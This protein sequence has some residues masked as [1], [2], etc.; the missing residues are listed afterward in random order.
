MVKG[1]RVI[2]RLASK[3]NK[4]VTRE[5]SLHLPVI[6]GLALSLLQGARRRLG[7]EKYFHVLDI[8]PIGNYIQRKLSNQRRLYPARLSQSPFSWEFSRSSVNLSRT[9]RLEASLVSGVQSKY[10][11]REMP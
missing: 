4:F 3:K 1:L 11:V 2:L 10:A 6:R 7:L 5:N 9:R 8:E